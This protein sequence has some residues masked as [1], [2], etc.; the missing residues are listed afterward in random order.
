MGTIIDDVGSA[1][2]IRQV[3]KTYNAEGDATYSYSDYSTEA[4]VQI[5]A[6]DDL[7]VTAGKMNVGDAQSFFKRTDLGYLKQGNLV[8]WNVTGRWYIIVGD[9]I[10][11]GFGDTVYFVECRL[12]RFRDRM[13]MSSTVSS[14]TRIA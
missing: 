11:E 5:M 4:V 6:E 2:T 9:P 13:T 12:Q 3:S 14:D 1:V 10:I 8:Q 7:M